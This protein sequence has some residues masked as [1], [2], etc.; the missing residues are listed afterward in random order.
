MVT[1]EVLVS[2]G[3]NEQSV[4]DRL[5]Q[6]ILEDGQV[7]TVGQPK[8]LPL[9]RNAAESKVVVPLTLTA[10]SSIL[11]AAKE[12]ARTLAG[13]IEEEQPLHLV[14]SQVIIGEGETDRTASVTVTMLRAAKD[15]GLARYFQERISNLSLSVEL[16][17]PIPVK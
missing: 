3:L 4:I 16:V 10:S 5:F 14:R 17:I 6:R 12:T 8:L 13:V 9:S 11:I 7:I 2:Q 1:G 15:L